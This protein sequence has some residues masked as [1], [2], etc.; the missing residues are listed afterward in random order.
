MEVKDFPNYLIFRNGAVLGKKR[1]KFLKPGFD[2]RGY[3]QVH[4][5]N[6]GKKKTFKVHRLVALHYLNKPDIEGISVDHINR[7]RTDNRLSNLRWATISQQNQ[8]KGINKNNT[9]RIQH[10]SFYKSSNIWIFR[11][12]INNKQFQFNNK[13]KQLVLWVKFIYFMRNKMSLRH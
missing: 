9:S 5:S 10:V 4:L 2:G 3:Y 1:K 7:I 13:N 6:R 12:I 8:N 11:K